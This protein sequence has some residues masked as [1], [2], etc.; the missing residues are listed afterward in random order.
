MHHERCVAPSH[1]QRRVSSASL[2][3]SQALA[4]RPNL[5]INTDG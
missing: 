3:A 2:A 1:A 5:V 4:V